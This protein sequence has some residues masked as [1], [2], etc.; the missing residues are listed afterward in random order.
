MPI[1]K[2]VAVTFSPPLRARGDAYVRGDK[3]HVDHADPAVVRATVQ[4]AVP[5]K[6]EIRAIPG[7]RLEMH[8]GCSYAQ[9][10]GNCEHLWAALVTCDRA[11]VLPHTPDE[12]YHAEARAVREAE[13]REAEA[14]REREREAAREVE[15]ARQREAALR[16]PEL[17]EHP[18]LR[19]PRPSD[20]R[21]WV[22]QL[23]S[24][25]PLMAPGSDA[26]KRETSA[27]PEGKRIIYIVDIP[28]T[29]ERQEG[30]L[31]E[32]G[33]QSMQKNGEWGA[34]RQFRLTR[35]QWLSAPELVDREVA[36]M[37][38][39]AQPEFGHYAPGSS[40]RRFLLSAAAIETT[41]RRMCDSGR[42]YIRP[43]PKAEDLVP[44]TWDD[45]DPWELRLAVVPTGGD[46]GNG[47][48]AN[49][50]EIDGTSHAVEVATVDDAPAASVLAATDNGASVPSGYRLE[51]HLARG[52]DVMLLAE[53][54]LFMRES[55]LIAR[56]QAS[57]WID[58]GAFD[59]V[60]ALRGESKVE[61]PKREAEEL[62]AEL[63]ALPHLPPLELPPELQLSTHEGAPM[64]RLALRAV[65]RTP[66]SPAKFEGVLSFDYDGVVV[67]EDAASAALFQGEERRIVRRNRGAE[68][69]FARRLEKAGFRWEYDYGS[70][71][72]TRRLSETRG[73][74]VAFELT[75][76]GW[77]VEFDGHLLRTAG[78]LSVSVTSGIDWFDLGASLD[79]GG[80]VS[81][82]L[83]ELLAAL[84]RGDRTVKLSDDSLGMLSGEWLEKSGFLAAAG[85][86]V[87]GNLRFSAR[88]L[89]VLDVLLSALPPAD[90]DA[91]FEHA[92]QQLL[93]FEGV[94]PAEAPEGFVGTLRPYQKEGLGW[95]YFLRDFG[96]GGCLADDMGL[97]KTVQV[98]AL[99]EERREEHG[100]TS[101]VVVPR[102]LVFNWEQE[103]KRFTPRLR[104]L[105]HGGPDRK[106]ST[107][108]LRDYDL[109]IT[110][111]GTLR[112]DVAMLREMEFDYA[113]LDEAQ[114]I[115]NA[116]TE[117]AKAARLIRARHRLAMTGTP[118]ENRLTELWSLLEFLNP[119]MLGKA[120]V[121]GS[122]IRRLDSPGN[123]EEREEAR[124]LLARAVRPYI[125]RRT[126]GQVAPELPERL[127]QTLVVDLS[128]KERA[129][130]N[131]LRDHYRNSLLGRIDA[132]GMARSKMH[133]LEAL[134]RLRQA[135][136]HPGLVD[137][138][139]R[140]DSSSKIDMLLTRV[141]E[142]TAEDHKVLV[143]SQF[144]SLLSIVRAQMDAA[145][146]RYAYLDGDTKDRQQVVTEFQEDPECKVFLVSL[147]A[148]GVGLNLTAAEYVYLLDP[149][150]NPA[151]EAQAIDRAHRIGQTRRVFA[152]RLIARDTVEEKVLALQESKR[153][154]A[155]AI[156]RADNS[157]V[158]SLG[159]EELELLL[160]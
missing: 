158:A 74:D 100:G 149:W 133:V 129:L 144:T 92:R 30:L 41:L 85:T 67:A 63:H 113:I 123:T 145:G 88:Q 128:P 134:L 33:M 35:A 18:A 70:A 68:E 61:V 109:I 37:L 26:Q 84:R 111:Y 58:H 69:T 112:R 34:P 79:F 48:A 1:P 126:K 120:S 96:F 139:R 136:C 32:L 23:R 49:A 87:G 150:W 116:G 72:Y 93:R 55:L 89:G 5:L 54:L 42:A 22:Q 71:R 86:M 25:A 124:T 10:Y 7:S 82:T 132:Q 62:V 156:I 119:G 50:E 103:A 135:A 125:L 138:S 36:Q 83:P 3:V 110:T 152:Q 159:R 39:G 142:A 47:A 147:K 20:P 95:L 75:I 151:V 140:D 154:L 157:V 29:F 80:G 137:P 52:D 122:L 108:H 8:C 19:P 131:E 53:P 51:G 43:T 102:S 141:A 17:P 56:G 153:D 77:F 90:T 27:Y 57:R 104:L 105:V 81:A 66:W 117:G 115:K 46:T 60:P 16:V 24:L 9:E 12:S 146:T 155:E 78:D 107:A 11:G 73:E 160:S 106:R 31:V 97:G 2:K 4:G 148:G 143:F 130:Y 14:R 64:P 94:H 91:A 98:L 99:L 38:L 28:L 76:E 45:G 40:T 101:L 21:P 118:I 59:L 44:L 6:V 13:E 121:F 127:E 114:A 15:E 65:A